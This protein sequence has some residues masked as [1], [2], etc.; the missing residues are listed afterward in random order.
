M[1][2]VNF[3]V[4]SITPKTAIRLY[5]PLQ[6]IHRL[7]CSLSELHRTA[8]GEQQILSDLRCSGAQGETSPQHPVREMSDFKNI[9]M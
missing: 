2:T 9:C 5:K 6:L 7:C 8:S 1:Q 3:A 4:I